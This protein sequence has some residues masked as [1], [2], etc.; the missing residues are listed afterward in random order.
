MVDEGMKVR[1]IRAILNWEKGKLADHMGVTYATLANWEHGRSRPN[2]TG[3]KKIDEI[4]QQHNI[5]IRPDGYPVLE[6]EKA[7]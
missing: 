3:Q 7:E 5:A 4:C 2:R 1:V 6:L